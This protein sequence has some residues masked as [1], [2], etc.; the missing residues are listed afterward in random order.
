MADEEY[1]TLDIEDQVP[2][3]RQTPPQV[4]VDIAKLGSV[5]E[6][7]KTDIPKWSADGRLSPNDRMWWESYL[8]RLKRPTRRK[9]IIPLPRTFRKFRP[10]TQPGDLMQSNLSDAIDKH[11]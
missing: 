7:M 1:R 4:P 10:P 2:T 6:G 8:Q 9:P 11:V 5:L 3:M